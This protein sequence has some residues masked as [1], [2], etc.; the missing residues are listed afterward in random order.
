MTSPLGFKARVGSA[1]FHIVEANVMYI[2]RDSP[3][4]LH[5]ANLFMDSISGHQLGSYFAQ[6]YYC[7]APVMLEAS[8]RHP[9]SQGSRSNR[10]Q[11]VLCICSHITQAVLE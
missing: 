5:I 9:F 10:V 4:V 8:T 3:L 2:P 6:G 1:F 7:V 11:P